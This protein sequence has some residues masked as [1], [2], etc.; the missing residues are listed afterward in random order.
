MRESFRFFNAHNDWTGRNSNRALR[1]A[2][3]EFISF[4]FGPSSGQTPSSSAQLWL[5]VLAYYSPQCPIIHAQIKGHG[6]GAWLVHGVPSSFPTGISNIP[7]PGSYPSRSH[8]APTHSTCGLRK[9][10]YLFPPEKTPQAFLKDGGRRRQVIFYDCGVLFPMDGW[11]WP[12]SWSEG[13]DEDDV[14]GWTPLGGC[15]RVVDPIA[16]PSAAHH[17]PGLI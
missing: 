7:C 12:T 9:L 6:S 11:I 4:H 8:A 13:G 3:I 14:D 2:C 16:A 15:G 10:P 5:P 17:W 1:H